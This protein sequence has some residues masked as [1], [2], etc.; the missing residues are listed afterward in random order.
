MSLLKGAVCEPGDGLVCSGCRVA[1]DEAE[2]CEREAAR[3]DRG[4]CVDPQRGLFQYQARPLL[5]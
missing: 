4:K 2:K 5:S 1:V 3:F